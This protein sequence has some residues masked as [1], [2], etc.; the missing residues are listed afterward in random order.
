MIQYKDL[1]DQPL[2]SVFGG[3][4]VSAEL[5]AEAEHFGRMAAK[6]G[7]II[8]NGGRMGVMEAV[9]KGVLEAGG[10][11]IALLPGEN[12]ETA[13][14]YN[15][16]A[17]ATGI[18]FARNEILACACHAAVAFGG[19]YGTL[20]EIAYALSMGK[21]VIGVKSWEISGMIHASNAGEAIEQ[22]SK[23]LQNRGKQ[24]G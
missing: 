2:I 4:D 23:A 11:S 19:H 16:I 3:R 6:A 1:R 7:W 17:I 8:L 14:P 5:M 12:L 22:L 13:N 24:D 21:T 9:S 15:Q 20:S 18:G 10:L